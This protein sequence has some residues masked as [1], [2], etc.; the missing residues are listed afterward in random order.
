MSLS[1]EFFADRLQVGY[2]RSG[3]ARGF[4]VF[5]QPTFDLD[6]SRSNKIAVGFSGALQIGD[7]WVDDDII[8]DPGSPS[9]VELLQSLEVL[10]A[11]EDLQ[12]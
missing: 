6:G 12:K 3:P 11:P 2:C 4:L 5:I 1:A 7:E 10:W 8:V 9:M